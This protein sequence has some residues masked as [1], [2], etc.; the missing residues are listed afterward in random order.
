MPSFYDTLDLHALL[1]AI[2]ELETG[3]VDD[4]V[5]KKG[6]ISRYQILP[7]VWDQHLGLPRYLANDP[8]F[9][10]AVAEEI[11]ARN[12]ER[13]HVKSLNNLILA[14]H[15]GPRW[16][17]TYGTKVVLLPRQYPTAHSYLQRA[18]TLYHNASQ[19]HSSQP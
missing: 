17:N 16:A 11:M 15:R 6:E 18:L 10:L 12:M 13:L 2:A 1:S 9:S 19:S 8:H 14:W 7:K 3:S 4:A 5:G